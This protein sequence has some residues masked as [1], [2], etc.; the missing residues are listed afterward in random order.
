MKAI[1]DILQRHNVGTALARGVSA[2]QIVE[3]TNDLL[4]QYFGAAIHNQAEAA[5]VKQKILTIICKTSVVS[6]EIRFKER[7][8]LLALHS[9]FG[10]DAPTRVRYRVELL[11]SAQKY[12]T[13]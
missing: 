6:Q 13:L 3:K 8:L 7:G 10:A 5:F 2:A 4:I 9:E 11:P 1:G 12:S